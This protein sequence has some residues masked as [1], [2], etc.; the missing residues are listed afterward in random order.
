MPNATRSVPLTK[1]ASGSLLSNQELIQLEVKSTEV[2][3]SNAYDFALFGVFADGHTEVQSG[4][5]LKRPS[6]DK[7]TVRLMKQVRSVTTKMTTCARFWQHQPS[8]ETNVDLKHTVFKPNKHCGTAAAQA[9]ILAMVPHTV[10][11]H[12]FAH[13]PPMLSGRLVLK[14]HDTFVQFL[15][16]YQ[17]G[18]IDLDVVGGFGFFPW[19]ELQKDPDLGSLVGK[20]AI[21]MQDTVSWVPLGYRSV[22]LGLSMD[23]RLISKSTTLASLS[24]ENC[25]R[26]TKFVNLA[27]ADTENPTVFSAL[28]GAPL[29]RL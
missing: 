9:L 13:P 15:R 25:K 2:F 22:I 21:L 14:H 11:W 12:K 23:G 16:C 8:N 10:S 6:F 26:A 24:H 1:F 28:Q 7:E 4:A 17:V 19:T 20:S 27:L 5:I 29:Q 3:S 18:K